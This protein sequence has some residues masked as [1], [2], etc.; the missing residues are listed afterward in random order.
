MFLYLYKVRY[1]KVSMVVLNNNFGW[2]S[3][4]Q[5]N[6]KGVT[7]P[8]APN[9]GN[10]APLEKDTFVKSE[11]I[12][13]ER[14][15]DDGL[16]VVDEFD[17]TTGK[18]VKLT[19]YF[20]DGKTPEI[21][22]EYDPATGNKIKDTW[23]Y[24]DGKTIRGIHEY[25]PLKSEFETRSIKFKEDG[26][27]IDCIDESDPETGEKSKVTWFRDDGKTI[28]WIDELN[29][30]TRQTVRTIWF[31]DDGKT[32]ARVD[33]RSPSDEHIK[34]KSILYKEDGKTIDKVINFD[35]KTGEEIKT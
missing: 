4:K 11:T 26:K 10:L 7:T 14:K 6:F 13:K 17:P 24:D 30:Q 18:K 12:K 16:R 20:K 22:G 29:P 31:N 2:Q 19:A 21:I 23:F 3:V 28:D 1:F 27:T 8:P 33:E 5:L 15:S 9:Y 32:I 25:N 35:P 34:V